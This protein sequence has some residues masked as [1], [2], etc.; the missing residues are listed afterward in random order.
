MICG[1]WD[2][3]HDRQIFIIL[4]RFLPFDPLNNPK[5]QNFEKI[6]KH[7]E[8]LSFYTCLPQ[9][10]IIWCTVPETW[11]TT[12]YFVILGYFLPFQPTNNPKN[13]NFEK[14]TKSTRKTSSL[15][16]SVPKIIIIS[17]TLPE[18]WLVADVIFILHFELFFALLPPYQLQK[19][20]LKKMKK[21]KKNIRRYHFSHMYHKLWSYDVWLL[22]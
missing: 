6:K 4:G 1:S 14:M 5:N 2:L 18:I 19:S 22:R 20:N 8:T 3:R 15:Y 9:M 13:Q 12:N 7:L 21:K 11:S 10:L 16:T 17:Y